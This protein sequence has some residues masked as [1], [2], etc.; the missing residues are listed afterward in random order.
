MQNDEVRWT[1]GQPH[2][3]AIVQALRF[4][5]FGHT[6]WMPGEQMPKDLNSFPFG[7]LEHITRTRSYY[8]DKDYPARP[9]IQQPL[10]EWSNWY[11]WESSTLLT[12]IYVWRYA[13]LVVHAR[14]EE[15]DIQCLIFSRLSSTLTM[16]QSGQWS[17]WLVINTMKVNTV[18]TLRMSQYKLLLLHQY[19]L[20]WCAINMH[21][22]HTISVAG[23]RETFTDSTGEC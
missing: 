15:E 21:A 3:S 22:D 8:V 19:L 18:L 20:Y 2:L 4:S 11:G 23:F 14:K 12:D 7:E 1:T 6:A 17:S 16:L 10:P 13:L 9:E 5:L